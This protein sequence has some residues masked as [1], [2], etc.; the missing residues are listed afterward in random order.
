[1][2]YR[3]PP[4]I[5]ADE[6]DSGIGFSVRHFTLVLLTSPLPVISMARPDEPRPESMYAML[7]AKTGEA[8][9][10]SALHHQSK[11]PFSGSTPC[12]AFDAAMS[13]CGFPETIATTGVLCA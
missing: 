1:M 6:S 12:K 2:R 3:Y 5:T 11:F 7:S 10:P 9:S 4:D 8:E 13:S